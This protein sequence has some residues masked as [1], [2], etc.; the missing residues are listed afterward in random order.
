MNAESDY[1]DDYDEDDSSLNSN[2]LNS[3]PLV[4]MSSFA[5]QR[6]ATTKILERQVTPKDVFGHDEKDET[7]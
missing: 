4:P 6:R 3:K 1:G 5:A 2:R 7:E